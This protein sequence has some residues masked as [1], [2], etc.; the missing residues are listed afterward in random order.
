MRNIMPLILIIVSIA[1]FFFFIDPQYKEVKSLQ[2]E[3]EENNKTLD[4]ATQLRQKREDL[5]EN[6]R[7]MK[8]AFRLKK[9]ELKIRLEIEEKELMKDVETVQG[10]VKYDESAINAVKP[11]KIIIKK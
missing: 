1:V 6:D 3:I 8:F 7:G 2:V 5:K 10:E 4:L 9:E 11:R